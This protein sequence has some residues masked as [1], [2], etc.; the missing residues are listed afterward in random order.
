[1]LV[2]KEKRNHFPLNDVL[3]Y[4]E[5][6]LLILKKREKPKHI[7]FDLCILQKNH[8]EHSTTHLQK[9]A[10]NNYA[11]HTKCENLRDELG[12]AGRRCYEYS[13]W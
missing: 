12:S 11:T 3:V 8:E 1:M 10:H 2:I 9:R 5:F 6:T 4:F 7:E 13:R